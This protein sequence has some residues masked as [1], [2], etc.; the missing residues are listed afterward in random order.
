MFVY[1]F[2]KFGYV[3]EA[4]VCAVAV[5][6]CLLLQFFEFSRYTIHVWADAGCYGELCAFYGV[7]LFVSYEVQ[8]VQSV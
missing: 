1:L 5:G 8:D 4:S 3:C 6:S 7:F 2:G